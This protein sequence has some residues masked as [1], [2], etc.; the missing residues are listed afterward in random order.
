METASHDI[1]MAHHQT[2]KPSYAVAK[3]TPGLAE[4]EI[5]PA[6]S[7]AQS[8]PSSPSAQQ[9]A[10]LDEAASPKGWCATEKFL[11]ASLVIG[12]NCHA[13]LS[14]VLAAGAIE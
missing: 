4:G 14:P 9:S 10:L 13:V 6:G 7:E 1:M 12:I 8:G 11:V 5:G 3:H 2:G